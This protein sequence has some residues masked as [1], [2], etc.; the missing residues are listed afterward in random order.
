[1]FKMLF[2]HDFYNK[3]PKKFFVAFLVLV[4]SLFYHLLV[5]P[6]GWVP[7]S[8]CS[9]ELFRQYLQYWLRY[10]LLP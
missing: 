5:T 10:M 6:L 1:M 2:S 7:A 8:Y 9:E 4:K 3:S